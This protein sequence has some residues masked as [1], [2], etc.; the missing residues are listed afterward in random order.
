L[1]SAALGCTLLAG[2]TLK[3]K[4]P[5]NIF[6]PNNNQAA[7]RIRLKWLTPEAQ[8]SI[9]SEDGSVPDEI[10]TG[11]DLMSSGLKVKPQH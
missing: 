5:A 4:I 8:C 11:N 6:R 1:N 10:R 2:R 9:R 3:T 7:Q